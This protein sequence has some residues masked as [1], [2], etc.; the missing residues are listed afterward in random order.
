F[1]SP[2]HGEVIPFAKWDVTS[3]GNM[4]VARNGSVYREHPTIA[5]F[6][7]HSSIPNDD[8][9]LQRAIGFHDGNP[10]YLTD[11][12]IDEHLTNNP[13]QTL[14]TRPIFA[15]DCRRMI[16]SRDDIDKVLFT[17]VTRRDTVPS[18]INAEKHYFWL[19]TGVDV[20]E[21]KF[22]DSLPYMP[23]SYRLPYTRTQ[24]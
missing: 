2:Y 14:A 17:Y 3:E 22:G 24:A 18:L 16:D 15:D 23:L 9:D 5:G 11:D 1:I 6:W 10:I 12:Q 7:Q 13:G 4:I 8:P 21:T 19:G 20:V